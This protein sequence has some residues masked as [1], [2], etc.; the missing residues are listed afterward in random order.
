MNKLQTLNDDLLPALLA[1]YRDTSQLRYDY[2]LFLKPSFSSQLDTSELTQTLSGFLSEQVE[3][4]AKNPDSARILKDNLPWLERH[5]RNQVRKIE[6]PTAIAPLLEKAC[7]SLSGHLQLDGENQKNLQAD[8]DQL[9]DISKEGSL[10][11]YG[12]FPALHLLMYLICHQVIP[13]QTEFKNEI[14]HYIKELQLLLDVD[15]TKQDKASSSSSLQAN[16]S[17]SQYFDT[18]SLSDIVKH[19]AKGSISMSKARRQRIENALNI[20]QQ[21]KEKDELVHIVHASDTLDDS[22]LDQSGCFAIEQ[23]DEPCVKATELFDKAADELARVFASARIA[24]LEINNDYDESIHDPWFENFNWEGFSK[25]ELILV[26]S[27]IVLESVNRLADEAMVSFSRL[28]NSGRPVNV[29]VRVQPHNN[30]GARDDEDPFQSF[31]TELGYLGISHRQAVVT[32][33]SAARHQHLLKHFNTSL[34]AT[35]TSL[36][37]ISVGLREAG[38]IAGLNAWLISGAALEGRAHPFFSVDPSAGDTAAERFDFEGNPHPDKDWPN[39]DFLFRDKQGEITEINLD[40]TFADYALLTSRLHHHFAPVP[41]ECHSD[42]LL[43]VAE[44]LNMESD[45]VSQCVPYVWAVNRNNELHRL[46]VSSALIHA[47]QD[48][49]N[50]W[51]T[52]QE[53]SGVRNCYV[54]NTKARMQSDAEMEVA[55]QVAQAKAEFDN[56]IE[57]LKTS[58]A[59]D[60]MS[61]LTD[62]LLDMDLSGAASSVIKNQTAVTTTENISDS[63][64]NIAA[65][66]VEVQAEEE[67]VEPEEEVEL[68]EDPWIDSPLCTTC[69]DCTDMNPLMFVYN[70]SKQ[71]YIEDLSAGTYKQMIEAAEICPSKC[72]HPGAPWDKS[73]SNL[74]ELMERAKAI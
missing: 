61:R 37:L 7:K 67:S 16:I 51:H 21:F 25:K 11:G 45:Q 65:T 31:R 27:V 66:D 49:L 74:N 54:E 18:Q 53:M 1:S 23:H 17:S 13:R 57:Q 12:R 72:I 58:A 14:E 63:S 22:W 33:S 4:F 5:L 56:E 41:V 42:D 15:D 8:L 10:L 44:Y 50:F 71:A 69:N 32:Q 46:V 19:T 48:R 60:V 29:F 59:V 28:L 70:D 39:H 64:D 6:G 35:R 62:M 2:P 9:L 30:P 24:E 36:H 43:T 52:L 73:E 20:L 38:E 47:C 3:S 34:N 26:P 55:K 40:F 68:S